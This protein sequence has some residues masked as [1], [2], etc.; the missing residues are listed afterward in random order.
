MYLGAGSLPFSLQMSD[1]PTTAGAAERY[2]VY[3]H[4]QSTHYSL[5]DI[6]KEDLSILIDGFHNGDGDVLIDGVKYWINNVFEIRVYT[7]RNS[8]GLNAEQLLR[9]G[10]QHGVALQDYMHRNRWYL[11][12]EVL[13]NMGEDVTK[14]HIFGK[15]G[16]R[17]GLA[18]GKGDKQVQDAVGLLFTLFM[19]FHRVAQGLRHRHGSRDTLVVKD[20]YDVQDL[21]RGLLGLHFDD[22]REEEYAPSYAG[23]NSRIDFVLKA[24]RIVVETKMT[25]DGLRDKELGSQLLV[26][27]GRYRSHPDCG[28]L[29]VFIY[30][31]LDHVRNKAGL[32]RDLEKMSTPE[33]KVRV[34]IAP[35]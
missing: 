30:D 9:E 4:T 18:G 17:K 26:D 5:L 19:R 27:I 21:L 10:R 33:L 24:E 12:P 22:I 1:S 3:I 7:Y 13:K 28:T 11:P 32:K 31:K 35:D 14:G 8:H 16:S 2:N 6:G 15:Q 29:I 34:F 25:N 20:E 23:A